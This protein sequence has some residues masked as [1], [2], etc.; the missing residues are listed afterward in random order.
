MHIPDLS[1]KTYA[2]E[3]HTGVRAFSV[4]WL[5][6]QVPSGGAVSAAV[7]QVLRYYREKHCYEDGD[8]GYHT[9]EICGRGDFHGEFW[10]ETGDTRYVLPVGVFHY[11]E[12]HGYCPPAEFLREIAALPSYGKPGA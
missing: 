5:G 4:G 2:P 8:L 7:M 10:I 3:A 1:T 9:C 12:A 11:I 6:K